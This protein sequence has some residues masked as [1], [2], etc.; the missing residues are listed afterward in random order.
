MK[1]EP[2]IIYEDADVIVIDKP[3]GLIVHS[4]GRTEEP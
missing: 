4:D 2:A 3:A 1:T